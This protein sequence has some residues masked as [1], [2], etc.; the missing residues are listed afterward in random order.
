[1]IKT[2]ILIA[3][4]VSLYL[5]IF[6]LLLLIER[7]VRSIPKK[8]KKLPLV[9][10]CIPAYNEGDNIVETIESV[11]DLDYPKEKLEIFVV[12]DGSTDNTREAVEKLL[13]EPKYRNVILLNQK[14]KGKGAAM[15]KA[16]RK[17][18]GEFFVPLDA[19][20]VVSKDALKILLSHFYTE[21]VAAVLPIIR[22][23]HKSSI[24]RK[25]QHCEYLINFF[26]KRLMSHINCVHVTPGPFS[27]YRK[28]V[29]LKLRG[30][31]ENNLVEDLEMAI[32]IQKANFEIVQILDTSI[33]TKAPAN[34]IQFYKQRNRWYKGSI[35]NIYN[36]RKMV[37]NKSYGDFGILQLPMVFVA[38]SVS[39]ILFFI[40]VF[41]KLLKP[42][43][44]KLYDWSHIEFDIMPLITKGIK[45]YTF[46]NLNYV[47][48]FYGLTILVLA[49]VFLVLAH[50]HSG[51]KLRHNKK[52]IFFYILVYPIMIGV[53]WT[54]VI[55]DLMRGKIQ[56]W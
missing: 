30:F 17:A 22:I 2:I 36:Y 42:V 26:Y 9:S 28:D 23:Q 34:F 19:D 43:I 25:I 47:P 1:M 10:I 33:F 54:G 14:N 13:K 38:A 32:K 53:I 37:F 27:V 39:I 29:I 6:W 31:D 18:K 46:L 16:L 11:V 40:L 41:W 24:M 12:N 5:V 7:G 51:E 44:N 35:I 48:L 8:L 20:S 21:N 52:S 56:K 3:Y 45:N 50:H 55:F 15:N 49:I 4:F